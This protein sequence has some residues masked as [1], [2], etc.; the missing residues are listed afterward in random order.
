MEFIPQLDGA[1]GRK[2]LKLSRKKP[3]KQTTTTTTTTTSSTSEHKGDNKLSIPSIQPPPLTSL[4]LSS[5]SLS[6]PPLSPTITTF[7]T[8]SLSSTNPLVSSQDSKP[9]SQSQ[10]VSSHYVP[11][12]LSLRKRRPSLSFYGKPS[13]SK[14]RETTPLVL[15]RETTPILD[16]SLLAER[17]R[18]NS[19]VPKVRRLSREDSE[20][21]LP[22]LRDREGSVPPKEKTSRDTSKSKGVAD[23]KSS[24][25]RR[26][27][28]RRVEATSTTRKRLRLHSKEEELVA[29]AIVQSL[30]TFKEEKRRRIMEDK[31]F[32]EREEE[33]NEM[34]LDETLCKK[35]EATDIKPSLIPA[36]PSLESFHPPPSLSP[37]PSLPPPLSPPPSL[38]PS[39]HT[40]ISLSLASPDTSFSSPSPPSSPLPHDSSTDNDY[41]DFT[42][43]VSSSDEEEE[44]EGGRIEM[45][46]EDTERKEEDDRSGNQEKIDGSKEKEEIEGGEGEVAVHYPAGPSSSITGPGVAECV[47]ISPLESAPSLSLVLQDGS[48]PSVRYTKAHCSNPNDVQQPQ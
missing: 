30:K 2:S 35:E 3:N 16:S 8:T 39:P 13:P 46:I 37:P 25:S 10:P 21:Y 15:S 11:K 33:K 41:L 31:E 45:D 43:A 47:V 42:L 19:L 48:M 14:S 38:P 29:L 5:P 44:R 6:P 36:P 34:E 7:T 20:K 24:N 23:S 22:A 32:Q 1:T 18:T 27:L 17:A 26:G 12:S 9:A 28:K 4:P 40:P